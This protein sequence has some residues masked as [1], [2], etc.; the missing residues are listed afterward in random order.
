MTQ[1][2][3]PGAGGRQ[4]WREGSVG[5]GK[6]VLCLPPTPGSHTFSPPSMGIVKLREAVLHLAAGVFLV[7]CYFTRYFSTSVNLYMKRSKRSPA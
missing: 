2:E 5:A 4:G 6:V 1:Q 3:A 7:R